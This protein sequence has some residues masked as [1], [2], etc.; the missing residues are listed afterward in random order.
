[1]YN[2]FDKKIYNLNYISSLINKVIF[3][4]EH[5]KTNCGNNLKLYKFNNFGKKVFRNV[6]LLQ[7]RNYQ[8]KQMNLDNNNN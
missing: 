5:K 8:Q 1:M 7:K 3:Y 2:Y 6:Y 4:F